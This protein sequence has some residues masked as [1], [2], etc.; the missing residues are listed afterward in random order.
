MTN[1]EEKPISSGHKVRPPIKKKIVYIEIDDE[2]TTIFDCVKNLPNKKIYLVVPKRAALFHSIVNLKIINKKL[3]DIDKE[4]FIVTKDTVGL[5]LA[6]QAEI[7]SFDSLDADLIG[8][9]T[10]KTKTN[11]HEPMVALSNEKLDDD[12]KRRRLKKL[13]IIEIVKKTR[14]NASSKF[15]LLTNI[16]KITEKIGKQN[17]RK[18]VFVT[19]S[20]RAFSTLIIA[21]IGLFTL[22]AYFALPGALIELTTS[23][24]TLQRSVNITLADKTRNPRLF[25][26]SPGNIIETYKVE[27]TINKTIQYSSTGHLFE[28]SN[29]SGEITI[30]N[31]SNHNWPLVKDTRFQ[32]E[33][34]LVFRIKTDAIIPASREI[35]KIRENRSAYA[36]SVPGELAVSVVADIEDAYGQVIGDKGNIGPSHFFVPGLSKESQNL[37]YGESKFNFTGGES[38]S[39]PRVVKEDISASKEKL[40]EVMK[41]DAV[42][43]LRDK[44]EMDNSLKNTN[45]KLMEDSF[46]LTFSEPKYTVA[47]DLIDKE[48]QE[49]D[50]SGEVKVTGIAYNFNE[51]MNILRQDL[52][53]HKSPDKRLVYIYDQSFAYD[54]ADIDK[55]TGIIKITA[56]IKGI[57]EFDIN[58]DSETG[59]RLIK[60]IKEHV[61]GK[62]KK[63]AAD[64]IQ[65]LPEIN[66]VNISTWPSW[67]PNLP[68]VP[69]NIKIEVI[70]GEAINVSSENTESN[71]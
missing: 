15:D 10:Q 29:S 14:D 3:V 70:Q 41:S 1:E 12:P 7:K 66:K 43:A 35:P 21:S 36:D 2:I 47:P 6:A 55:Q 13:S 27:E 65:N 56:S 33:D 40:L 20:K 71:N 67:A 22:I 34:G 5:K 63:E 57:E 30:I 18:L 48:L 44:I 64:Y 28:G 23:P 26:T 11:V 19:P 59:Q 25:S 39:S 58:P 24:N 16:T 49:F 68:A 50:V 4:L 38:I 62:S 51:V 60:K 9:Q 42:S 8:T 54:I 17:D 52:Q 53:T 61:I 37:L 46:V 45:L 32:T 69:E 31:K